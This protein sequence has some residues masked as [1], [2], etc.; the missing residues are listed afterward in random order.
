M[1][2]L[3]TPYLAKTSNVKNY[4]RMASKSHKLLNL[5]FQAESPRQCLTIMI[6]IFYIIET[7]LIYFYCLG[8]SLN[9]RPHK[10]Q[11]FNHHR[12]EIKVVGL[13]FFC[14]SSLSTCRLLAT[15]E[16]LFEALLIYLHINSCSDRQRPMDRKLITGCILTGVLFDILYIL[17]IFPNTEHLLAIFHDLKRDE[18]ML[19]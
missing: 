11:R 7:V 8:L 15:D 12:V 9:A 10:R 14:W 18:G 17:T 2:N 3:L 4:T 5:V 13:F 16:A 6:T 1:W 19:R